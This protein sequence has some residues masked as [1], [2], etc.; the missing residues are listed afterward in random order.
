MAELTDLT[1]AERKALE[2][3]CAA[4]F[5]FAW[6]PMDSLHLRIERVDLLRIFAQ[7]GRLEAKLAERDK[8]IA[9]LEGLRP[10]LEELE[11]ICAGEFGKDWG[12]RFGPLYELV[13]QSRAAR[14]PTHP[15][16][17][18][19]QEPTYWHRHIKDCICTDCGKKV[20]IPMD[21]Y[22]ARPASAGE[23]EVKP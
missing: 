13:Q 19:A 2:Y 9:E 5:P 14:S 11:S 16:A 17:T 23:P 4:D 6:V 12:E 10:L 18:E 7:I 8:R 20:A 15:V 3:A 22:A 21:S 1:P